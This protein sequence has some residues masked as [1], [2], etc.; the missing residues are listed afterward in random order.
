MQVH[1]STSVTRCSPHHQCRKRHLN[2]DI[3]LPLMR[4]APSHF[5]LAPEVLMYLPCAMT[6]CDLPLPYFYMLTHVHVQTHAHTLPSSFLKSL[7]EP[8]KKSNIIFYAK[9]YFSCK[10]SI[11]LYISNLEYGT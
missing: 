9:P 1:K 6:L 3:T 8:I 5:I 7:L 11:N 10:I 2:R 4:L